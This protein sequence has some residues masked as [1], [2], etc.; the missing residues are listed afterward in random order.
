MLRKT[1]IFFLLLPM[2]LYSQNHSLVL[3]NDNASFLYYTNNSIEVRNFDNEVIRTLHLDSDLKFKLIEKILLGKH[4]TFMDK[5]GV[6]NIISK[7]SGMYYRSSNDTL[8]RIDNSYGHKMTNGSDVFV[9]NDTVFKFGGYGYWSNRN[10]F[11]YFDNETKEWEYYPISPPL[12]PPSISFFGSSMTA[13]NYFVYGGKLVDPYTGGLSLHNKNVWTFNFLSK[14]WTNLGVSNIQR[15]DNK[16][17]ISIKPDLKLIIGDN[18]FDTF[19]VSFTNNQIATVNPKKYS[20]NFLGDKAFFVGDTIF[21]LNHKDNL[22]FSDLKSTLDYTEPQKTSAIYTNTEV[23][24]SGLTKT[25]FFS[26]SLLIVLIMYLKYKRNQKPRISDFGIRFKGI[27]YGFKSKE[28][29]MIELVLYNK[30]VSSQEMYDAVEDV[31]LSYPQNNKIKNDTI[32]RVNKKIEK[33]LGIKDFIESKKLETDGR[34]LIY[35]TQYAN[36]FVK[37]K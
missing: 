32:K 5:S 15:F 19:F 30:E 27:S 36:L 12:T 16:S 23:L 14:T 26:T 8:Y 21:N 17:H 22:I 3:W 37:N 13:D 20:F 24:F 4:Y 6:V 11:T 9:R 7:P 35:F 31:S 29:K 25:A 34:I 33:I 1:K 18:G 10:M 28:K 2:F